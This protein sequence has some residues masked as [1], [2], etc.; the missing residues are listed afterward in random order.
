MNRIL[1]NMFDKLLV[2]VEDEK[3]DVEAQPYANEK[4]TNAPHSCGAFDVL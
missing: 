3:F 1:I 4:Q 2:L